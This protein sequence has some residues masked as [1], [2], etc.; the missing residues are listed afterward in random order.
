MQ[1]LTR[2]ARPPLDVP[3]ELWPNM[4][5]RGVDS[6]VQALLDAAMVLLAEALD[7]STPLRLTAEGGAVTVEWRPDR[8]FGVRSTLEWDHGISVM[9]VIGAFAG[10]TPSGPGD[11]LRWPPGHF[12]VRF[13]GRMHGVMVAPQPI[14]TGREV[15]VAFDDG[16]FLAYET[17]KDPDRKR[18]LL[19]DF[20]LQSG[21][22]KLSSCMTRVVEPE[23]GKYA[24]IGAAIHEA[25]GGTRIVVRAGRYEEN[26][27]IPASIQLLGWGPDHVRIVSRYR[28]G[29]HLTARRAR[30]YGIHF[31]VVLD[32]RCEPAYGVAV[33]AGESVLDFCRITSTSAAC[34]AV[35]GEGARPTVRNCTIHGI[36]GG[37]YYY[38]QAGGILEGCEISGGRAA[39][40]TVSEGA[41][42]IVQRCR[43]R[44]GAAMGVSIRDGGAALLEGCEITGNA[45]V[46]VRIGS[47]GRPTLR[48][49]RIRKNG[50]A[51]IQAAA[52][53]SGLVGECDLRE[54]AGGAWELEGGHGLVA[55]GNQE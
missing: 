37:A 20:D 23:G 32:E 40:L 34:L 47:D 48:G 7:G 15:V 49:C 38:R 14:P 11:R 55:E 41:A 39:G 44:D 29:L 2:R 19:E 36:G 6:R 54:N 28:T 1:R 31:D 43:I 16:S 50:R 8:Q 9:A 51:G 42:P 30:V 25:P 12:Q 33:T 26:L 21:V 22:A 13:R 27:I 17:E 45:G 24:T 10:I 18:Q 35:A 52:G 53:A 4:E 46:G 3:I 5:L